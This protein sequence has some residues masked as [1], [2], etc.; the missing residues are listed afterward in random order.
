MTSTRSGDGCCEEN[1]RLAGSRPPTVPEHA[2]TAPV[3]CGTPTPTARGDQAS[4]TGFVRLTSA[5]HT[6]PGAKA[7]GV[8]E[9]SVKVVPLVADE[10]VHVTA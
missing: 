10:R 2:G 8:P 9:A 6:W 4:L 7:T 5:T 3:R 1:T